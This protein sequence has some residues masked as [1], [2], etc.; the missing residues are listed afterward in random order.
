MG[1]SC[2][3]KTLRILTVIFNS[4]FF[5]CGLALIG[6]SSYLLYSMNT[7]FPDLKVHE[8]G[9]V[10]AFL[11]I[12]IIVCVL[13]FLGCC[14]ALRKSVCML[15]TFAVFISIILILDIVVIVLGFIQKDKIHEFVTKF[16]E[17]ALEKAKTGNS[18]IMDN[19]Q[20]IFM[21]CGVNG[22]SDYNDT[23]LPPS[24]EDYTRGC[25]VTIQDAISEY[26]IIL[27]GIALATGIFLLIT[28][29]VAACIVSGIRSYDPVVA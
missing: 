15:T 9:V 24:C 1:L 29:I 18:T 7:T 6:F 22:T 4:I 17:K 11:V 3:T 25:D 16:L 5:L 10:I 20:S 12:G 21:C 26:S 2:A 13:S 19:V 27:F 28:L 8:S 14:G 23:V